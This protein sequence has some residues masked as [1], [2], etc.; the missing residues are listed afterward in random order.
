MTKSQSAVIAGS[1]HP[2]PP[3]FVRE[4]TTFLSIRAFRAKTNV[5]NQR[6]VSTEKNTRWSNVPKNRHI[7]TQRF[8]YAAEW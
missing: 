1:F 6:I 7:F 2:C 4:N 3:S 8:T 5:H